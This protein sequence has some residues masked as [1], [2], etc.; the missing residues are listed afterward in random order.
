MMGVDVLGADGLRPTIDRRADL[1][2]IVGLAALRN[3]IYLLSLL[4]PFSRFYSFLSMRMLWAD[5]PIA[6]LAAS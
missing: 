3:H 4:S 6:Q 2:F 5:Q 1:G